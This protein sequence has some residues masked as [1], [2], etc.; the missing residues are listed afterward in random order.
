MLEVYHFV[1]PL[2]GDSLETEKKLASYVTTATEKIA[3][4]VV[5]VMT[6]QS[7]HETA[8]ALGHPEQEQ[9]LSQTMY[10]FILD[11]KALQ[12]QGKKVARRFLEAAQTAIFSGQPY[13]DEFV[14]G[15]VADIAAD[16]TLFLEDRNSDLTIQAYRADHNMAAEMGVTQFPTLV[17][18][19]TNGANHASRT[20]DFSDESLRSLITPTANQQLNTYDGYLHNGHVTEIEEV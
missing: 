3:L 15:L 5:P 13:T 8:V 17:V 12:F 19:N 2:S 11:V 10:R 14:M 16:Q 18:Y 7:V 1:N 9:V 20:T 4:Q 6:M